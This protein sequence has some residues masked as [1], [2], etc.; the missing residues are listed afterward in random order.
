M[1]VFGFND[2]KMTILGCS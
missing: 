1:L 2:K